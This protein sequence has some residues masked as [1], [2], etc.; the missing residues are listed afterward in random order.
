M[1]VRYP[2]EA[3]KFRTHIRSLLA[4]NLPSNWSGAGSLGDE[5]R[6][7]FLSRWRTFMVDQGLLGVTIPPEY[8]GAGLSIAEQVVLAE[9]LE[10]AKV[11]DGTENDDI[12]FQ[13]VANTML[14]VGSEEIKLQFLPKII[15]GEHRWCQ[16]FSE[17]EAGSDL[18]SVRTRA[19]LN[20]GNWCITGQKI[21][22]SAAPTA[23]WIFVLARTQT[24]SRRHEG[25]S[26][27]LVPMDQPGVVVRPIKNAAG[28]EVFSEVFFTDA[29]T[30]AEYVLGGV[31][32][33]WATAMTMLEF[34]RG[35]TVATAAA[36]F[37]RDFDDILLL[38]KGRGP[39]LNEAQRRE[40]AW[41]FARLQSMRYRGYAALTSLL[42]GKKI[43]AEAA[44]S[45][46][47]W[48]EYFQRSTSLAADLCGQELLAPRGRGNDGSL[49]VPSA[50]S[51]NSSRRWWEELMYSRA[52]T[53]YAGSSQIQKNIIGER[54]LHLPR[55][56]R[57]WAPK[58]E[59]SG[60]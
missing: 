19:V 36:R 3:E 49:I 12:G 5:E 28:Y 10:R 32:N 54:L 16:G 45:K 47:I 46:L 30:R 41:C 1:D 8:G 29:L 40:L 21:W 4:G 60:G 14:A 2:S 11:P 53:V 35:A 34:E 50:G 57:A 23:N 31:G 25:L 43:G 58:S 7:A 33:G 17:P 39:K 26:F 52:S 59:A 37:G 38:A 55:E 18:A 56:P 44:M 6:A 42:A 15:T 48:S 20:E 24:G 27:L 51:E 9:E 13:L 22:T